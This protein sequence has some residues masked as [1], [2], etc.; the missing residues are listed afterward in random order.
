MTRTNRTPSDPEWMAMYRQ[1][2]PAPR[3]A[4]AAGVAETTV[5]RHLATAARQNSELRAAHQSAVST[6][7]RVTVPGRRNLDSSGQP[8]FSPPSCAAGRVRSW[9]N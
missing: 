7:R 8:T 5:R 2:V 9:M 6:P 3:I 4:A 1:G